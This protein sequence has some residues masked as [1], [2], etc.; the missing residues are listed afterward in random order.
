VQYVIGLVSFGTYNTIPN[1]LTGFNNRFQY[2]VP[3]WAKEIFSFSVPPD[4]VKSILVPQGNYEIE[5]LAEFLIAA[6]NDAKVKLQIVVDKNTFRTRVQC[7]HTIEF[8]ASDSVGKCLGFPHSVVLEP[9][10]W[11]DSPE[12][13]TVSPVS[14][15]RVN[16]NIARGSYMNAAEC[17][18]LF[19]FYPRVPPGFRID[20]APDTVIYLPTVNNHLI[21][22]ITITF[23][24]QRGE[25]IDFL[26][27]EVTVVL[28]LKPYY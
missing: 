8:S 25:A 2:H 17:H 26:N 15:V 19:A 14:I 10:K 12:L 7:D 6:A 22:N 9:D 3:G 20:E 1:I 23:T 18:T 16:C 27:E 21:Q 28:H 5:Q 13:I 11:H 24:D 4:E